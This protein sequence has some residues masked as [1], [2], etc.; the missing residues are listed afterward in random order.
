MVQIDIDNDLTSPDEYPF[1]STF[2]GG[3][4]ASVKAVPLSEQIKQGNHLSA[5]Y[6]SR[7]NYMP[8]R[9]LVVTLPF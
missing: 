7:L 5:F 2:E 3:A 6:N 4:D 8:R 9:F 1:A